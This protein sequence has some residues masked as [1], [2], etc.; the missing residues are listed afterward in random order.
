MIISHS[1]QHTCVHDEQQDSSR[2]GALLVLY[3]FFSFV[4]TTL[5][6]QGYWRGIF[7]MNADRQDRSLF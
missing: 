7:F 1:K 4:I 6:D 5:P 2:R 3:E